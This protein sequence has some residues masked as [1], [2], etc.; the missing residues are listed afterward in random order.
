MHIDNSG[1]RI[2]G[3]KRQLRPMGLHFQKM[4]SRAQVVEC[5]R[6]TLADFFVGLSLDLLAI[7]KISWDLL[8]SSR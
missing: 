5:L 6:E 8:G 4:N 2:T 3:R 7:P 1:E